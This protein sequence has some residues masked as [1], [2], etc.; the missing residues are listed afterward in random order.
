MSIGK[1]IYEISNLIHTLEVGS[2]AFVDL[3]RLVKDYYSQYSKNTVQFGSIELEWKRTSLGNLDS[4]TFFSLPEL[5][6]YRYY[7]INKNKYN[8]A[9][10]VGANT[11]IDSL[12]LGLNGYDVHSFEPDPVNVD[13]FRQNINK[14]KLKNITIHQVAL[15]DKNEELEFIRVE[16]NVTANHVVTA[17]NSYGDIKKYKVQGKKFEDVGITPDLMKI[18]IEGSEKYLVPSIPE[19][20]WC[21]CDTFIEVH[22]EDDR[23]IV[24]DY[25][26]SINMNM[27]SNKIGWQKISSVNDLPITYKDGY[28]FVTKSDE[29][30]WST[31]KL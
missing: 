7:Q 6:L 17:R 2:E 11:G 18:N 23:Q 22:S 15:S 9:F 8:I 28:M 26:K 10:D 30:N 25:L 19:D 21:K 13:L 3:D 27:F 16:G 14:N 20:V 12:M 1:T 29:M 24:Y 31:N 4:F 5:M